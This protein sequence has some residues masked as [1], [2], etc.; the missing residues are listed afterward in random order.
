MRRSRNASGSRPISSLSEPDPLQNL[1]HTSDEEVSYGYLLLPRNGYNVVIRLK[2]KEL[3]NFE[4][5]NTKHFPVSR[6]SLIFA[7][8]VLG[9]IVSWCFWQNALLNSC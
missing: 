2:C 4:D 3:N 6:Y 9:E 5:D 8:N 7:E 1:V